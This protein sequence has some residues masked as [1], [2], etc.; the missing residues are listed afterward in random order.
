MYPAECKSHMPVT[1]AFEVQE[2]PTQAEREAGA[3]L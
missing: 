3:A 2:Q 1:T